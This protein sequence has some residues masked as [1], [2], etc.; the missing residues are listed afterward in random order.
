MAYEIKRDNIIGV[1][2]ETNAMLRH[3]KFNHG[4][5]V[6]GLSELIGHIVADVANNRIQADELINLAV[7]HIRGTVQKVAEVEGKPLIAEG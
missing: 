3:H 1:A 4:E 2:R 7:G 6:L 5:V